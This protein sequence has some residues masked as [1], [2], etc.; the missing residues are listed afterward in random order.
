MFSYHIVD[1]AS[2]KQVQEITNV[3]IN[4]SKSFNF[5]SLVLFL[6]LVF[7]VLL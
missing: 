2:S 1:Y 5:I 3:L 6:F 4:V 7:S